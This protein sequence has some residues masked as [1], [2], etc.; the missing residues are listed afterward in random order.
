M[1]G[2]FPHRKLISRLLVLFYLLTG[3]GFGT[4]LILCQEA[5]GFSHLAFNIEGK[6]ENTCLPPASRIEAGEQTTGP[7][8]LRSL[9]HDCLDT[10]VSLSHASP[11]KT[12]KLPAVS[13]A[14]AWFVG[15]IFPLCNRPVIGL[16]RLNLMAQ[17]PPPQALAALGTI[18]LLN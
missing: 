14:P 9:G 17:P 10:P 18:V 2:V 15:H 11:S 5:E 6:C 1:T 3:S 12:G 7:P 13:A 4:V 8:T 16:A